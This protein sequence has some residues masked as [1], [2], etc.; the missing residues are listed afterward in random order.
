MGKEKTIAQIAYI[1]TQRD[2][3]FD[4]DLSRVPLLCESK[5]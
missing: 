4:F 3:E 5:D 1:N 2:H